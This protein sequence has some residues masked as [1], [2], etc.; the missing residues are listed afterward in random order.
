MKIHGIILLALWEGMAL[1]TSCKETEEKSCLTKVVDMKGETIQVW[2]LEYDEDNRLVK[3]GETSVGYAPGKIT[4]GEMKWDCRGESM[5]DAT[6]FLTNGKVNRSE[7]HCQISVGN[8]EVNAL[9]K[10][11]Y[12]HTEDTLSIVSHYYTGNASAPVKSVETTYIYD[13]A[14]R[15]SEILSVYYDDRGEESDA[16][17]CYF[18]YEANIHYTSN[19]NILAFVVDSEGLDTFFYLLLNLCGKKM[20]NS[21]PNRIHHCVNHGKATYTADGLYRLTGYTPTKLEV[22]SLNTELKARFEF[23]DAENVNEEAL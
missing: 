16:C 11:F 13:D 18:G 23:E 8:R 19:L 15:I 2:E 7:A 5:H 14:H 9:K 17:H 20:S 12:H 4:V 21:L 22:I 1:L 3:Y 10:T 6:F